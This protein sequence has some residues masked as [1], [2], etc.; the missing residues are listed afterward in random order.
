MTPSAHF[1]NKRPLD[2]LGSSILPGSNAILEP[3]PK[4]RRPPRNRV[5]MANSDDEEEYSKEMAYKVTEES[6]IDDSA[7]SASARDSSNNADNSSH[8]SDLSRTKLTLYRPET[9][10]KLPGKSNGKAQGRG[11]GKG[12]A[13]A[14][15][16]DSSSAS[17]HGQLENAPVSGDKKAKP[18]SPWTRPGVLAA[19]EAAQGFVLLDRRAKLALITATITMER[20]KGMA[21]EA[22]RVAAIAEK[23]LEIQRQ[24]TLEASRR[25]LIAQEAATKVAM[26]LLALQVQKME[27]EESL[28]VQQSTPNLA[29]VGPSHIRGAYNDHV[30]DLRQHTDRPDSRHFSRRCVYPEYD[31]GYALADPRPAPQRLTRHYTAPAPQRPQISHSSPPDGHVNDTSH[32]SSGYDH[33]NIPRQSNSRRDQVDAIHRPRPALASRDHRVAS[34]ALNHGHASASS[35]RAGVGKYGTQSNDASLKAGSRAARADDEHTQFSSL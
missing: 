33:L 2:E 11:K 26:D 4:R 27:M 16:V 12:K 5:L 29:Q 19:A 25:E 30:P 7:E 35:S 1:T 6:Q 3:P 34:G 14:M 17:H 24:I 10:L 8:V 9:T 18:P 23:E 28:K 32:Y 20:E 21:E 15:A 31:D 13:D 22:K